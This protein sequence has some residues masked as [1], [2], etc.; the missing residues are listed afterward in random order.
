MAGDRRTIIFVDNSTGLT[1]GFK[2][3]KFLIASLK[4]R[5]LIVLITPDKAFAQREI[6]GIV[7]EEIRFIE[8][9]KSVKALLYPFHLLRNTIRLLRIVDKYPGAVL[10]INDFYNLTGCGVKWWRNIPLVYHVRLLPTSYLGPLYGFLS[11]VV[12][13]YANKVIC[14]SK[15]VFEALPDSD[16]KLVIYDGMKETSQDLKTTFDEKPVILYL[17][18]YI[19]GKGH[20][21]ALTIF[22]E[23]VKSFPDVSMRFF[24]DTL[25]QSKNSDFK[26]QLIADCDN[27]KLSNKVHFGGFC[28]DVSNEIKQATIVLN[29]SSSESFSMVCLEGL[30]HGTTV[31]TLD[32][33]GPAELISNHETGLIYPLDTEDKTLAVA[34]GDLLQRPVERRRLSENGRKFALANFSVDN[35]V[36][37]VEKVYSDI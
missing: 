14:C 35:T 24:G 19:E 1:G 22:A 30:W 11:R 29:C 13:R 6:P 31:V 34:I 8:V 25:H 15:A 2:S 4:P 5:F 23:L 17:A 10:H 18:N 33:G 28:A 32:S 36:K 7:H 12:L 16:K 37:E 3:L 21:R 9:R 27:F 20:G 26:Q